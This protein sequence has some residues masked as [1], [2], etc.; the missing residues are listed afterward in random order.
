M[1]KP[2]MQMELRAKTAASLQRVGFTLIELLVVVAIIA[3][4]VSILLPS[5]SQARE[6]ARRSLCMSNLHHIGM[7]IHMYANDNKGWSPRTVYDGE[8]SR[9]GT[10]VWFPDPEYNGLPGPVALGLLIRDGYLSEDGHIVFCPSQRHS[11]HI[12]DG[13]VGW[14]EW[15]N[16][17]YRTSPGQTQFLAA[18]ISGYFTRYAQK[19]DGN[20]KAI[21]G[22]IWHAGHH[23]QCHDYGGTADW[24][25]YEGPAQHSG[26]DNGLNIWYSDGSVRWFNASEVWWWD[27]WLVSIPQVDL[28]WEE[29]LDQAY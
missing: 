15:G 3:L 10:Y 28:F 24:S 20:I 18:V 4:L 21:T 6:L 9:C 14:K 5:L 17:G 19:M 23:W 11:S 26:D 25:L 22:D 16:T 7:G 12:Y 27:Q 8:D 1:N 13:V 29:Q 2:P